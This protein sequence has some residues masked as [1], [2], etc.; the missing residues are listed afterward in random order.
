MLSSMRDSTVRLTA[1]GLAAQ[2]PA[3]VASLPS[4]H[5]TPIPRPAV[6]IIAD[7]GRRLLGTGIGHP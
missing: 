6:L 3:A 1:V 5:L 7:N 4:A 2:N